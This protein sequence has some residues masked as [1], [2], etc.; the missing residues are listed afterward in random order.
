MPT[1]LIYSTSLRQINYIASWM[2]DYIKNHDQK[3]NFENKL[4]HSMKQFVQ[5]LSDR[6][7]LVEELMRNEKERKLSLFGKHI[8]NEVEYFG[9]VYV[10]NYKGSFAQFAQAQRHRTIDYQMELLP[11]KQYFIPT[12]IE[13][14]KM[15][16]EEWMQ[17]MQ[18]VKG[19]NPQGELVQIKEIGKYE[20]FI[21]KCKERLCSAA[22]LEIM[23]QTKETLLKYKKALE[24]T[25]HPLAE[26]IQK[27]S[28]GARCTFPDYTCASVCHFEE[29]KR[30][31]R[32][33]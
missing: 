6:N 14:D 20:D 30:L 27:Y 28:H 3:D 12:I 25:N 33:I 22:Q 11:E 9:S 15:L 18:M 8:A 19:I 31:T 32:K 5:Q 13:K 17:D 24:E 1:T 7:I 16:V 10:T 2:E 23:K 26:D 4:A 21:L 29:G